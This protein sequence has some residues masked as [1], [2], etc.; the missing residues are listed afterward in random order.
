M[1]GI[2]T[3]RHSGGLRQAVAGTKGYYYNSTLSSKHEGGVIVDTVVLIL[4]CKRPK[5][6]ILSHMHTS[7]TSSVPD[8]NQYQRHIIKDCMLQYY[9]KNEMAVHNGLQS[10]IVL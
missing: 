3:R 4:A 8:S 9:D 10:S 5:I 7:R 2:S 1:A 6:P